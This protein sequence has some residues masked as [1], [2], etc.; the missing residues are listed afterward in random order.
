LTTIAGATR[1]RLASREWPQWLER[2]APAFLLAPTLLLLLVF[3]VYP[4]VV[5][6]SRSFTEPSFGLENYT[7]LWESRA[8]RAV[9]RNTFV[10]AAWTT[11]ISLV[12]AYPV[13]YKLATLPTRWARVLLVLTLVPLF[14]AILARLYAWTILLGNQGT[15]NDVLVATGITDSPVDLLFTRTAVVVGMVHVMLPY[16]ILVLYSTMVGID[17]SLLDAARS[18][19]ASRLQT[20]RRVFLP[21]SMPGVYAGCL[22]VFILSLGFF[23][24]PAVL[25]GPGD[26]TIATFV[27]QQVA[28]LKWGAATAM[29]V[30]LVVVTLILF[31]FFDRLFGTERLLTG[32]VRK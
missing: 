10:I 27:Q 32:G 14:T 26:L 12:L 8:F 4:L 5:V 24:T 3:F 30:V 28:I 25:G 16:M 1:D 23:I 19:G 17:R 15:V 29:S 21:L 18:L 31:V 9:M 20:F 7:A 11:V 6:L 13:A 22:L 2:A